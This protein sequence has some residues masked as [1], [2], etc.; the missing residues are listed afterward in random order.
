MQLLRQIHTDAGCWVLLLP[1]GKALSL[2]TCCPCGTVG[3]NP[4]R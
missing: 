4:G 3:G 2:S 1:G